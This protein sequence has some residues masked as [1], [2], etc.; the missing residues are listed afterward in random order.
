M[1]QLEVK[2]KEESVPFVDRVAIVAEV[3]RFA[4]ST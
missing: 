4:S 2:D 1:Y 3:A